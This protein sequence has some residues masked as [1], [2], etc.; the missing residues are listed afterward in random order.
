MTN[1]VQALMH[2]LTRTMKAIDKFLTSVTFTPAVVGYLREGDR[3]GL[4][5]RK[6]VSSGLGENLVAGIG[7]KVGDSLEIQNE[8]PDAAMDREASEEI[9]VKVLEKQEMGRVR[10]IFSHKPPDSPWNQDVTIYSIT[11]WEGTPSETD[12]MKPMWF[13]RNE[14]PWERM[15]KD[16]EYW[17]PKVL[18]GE[19]VDAVF[20]FSDDNKIAE[21]RFEEAA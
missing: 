2:Y 17:L 16:N 8:T 18:S 19:R 4:G 12:S 11:S 20:L 1:T 10:F 5:I 7:G 6:K 9:G 15:W 3:V 13:D 14:L 21:Y